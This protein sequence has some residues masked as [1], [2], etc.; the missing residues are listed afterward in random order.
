MSVNAGSFTGLIPGS[1]V[2]VRPMTPTS[3]MSIGI[4]SAQRSASQL[5]NKVI[6]KVF[7]KAVSKSGGEKAS[8]FKTFTLRNINTRDISTCSQL[9]AL[10][11]DQL[12]TDITQGSFDVGYL[13]NN[14]VISVR[15]GEDL[16]EI[17]ATL[18][19]GTSIMLW[20]DGLRQS[21]AESAS[22]SSR[23]KRKRRVSP[24]S[25]KQA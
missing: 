1:S 18:H 12:T 21:A 10:I 6:N 3:A 13:Q 9:R 2:S 24:D 22:T 8:S 5:T 4:Q 19:K 25:A 23:N 7:L 14:M 17:W 16:A 20:C 11:R 15:N